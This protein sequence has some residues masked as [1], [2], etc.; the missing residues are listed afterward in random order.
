VLEKPEK[1]VN[2][3]PSKPMD[4]YD[5]FFSLVYQPGAI[6]AKTKHLIALA[7]SLGNG[8]QP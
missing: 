7:A 1:E 8:C 3:M 5:D 2:T 6:D 4:R